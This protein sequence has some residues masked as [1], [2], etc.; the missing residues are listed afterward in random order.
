M[1]G[2]KGVGG[3]AVDV[4][5]ES[6]REHGAFQSVLDFVKRVP[7]RKVNKKVLE[8]L[9]YA[10]AFDTIAEVNR[11]SLHASLEALLEH[12]SDEQEEKALGQ[13]SL[14]DQF[15]AQELK[16]ALPTN[17]L[18]KQE[19]DWPQ[20]RKFAFEKQAVGF[21]VSGHPME[22]WQQICADW[23]GWST[24]RLKKLAEDRSKA[25]APPPQQQ[26]QGGY[27]RPKRAEIQVA[28]LLTEMREVTTKK[29]TRM[30]FVQ[31]EDLDGKV[32]VIVFPD[33]YTQLQERLR[34]AIAEVEVVVVTG[35]LEIKE[36]GAK[37]LAK[38]IE[39]AKDAHKNRVQQVVL[40]L[41]TDQVSEEQLRELKKRFL[42]HRGK[43]PVM[44][45]FR[46]R[47]FKTRL[48]LPKT[49]RVSGTP[50]MV[51]SV[52]QIFGRTVVDLH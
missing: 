35:E 50:Q 12:A 9:N 22:N 28:G 37:I 26:G 21:Y 42:E 36:E 14:F 31:L 6:R 30:A 18:F 44:I 16:V 39:W 23:L 2:I 45:H 5:L 41:E 29:G 46:G 17:A 15:Q 52:N 7:T 4:I 13:S 43:C 47:G 3:V 51:A 49:V 8:S 27:Q 1:E 20:A 40:K 24:E 10:G 32:E 38:S 25:P 33:A 34:Q 48:E 11:P 19:P